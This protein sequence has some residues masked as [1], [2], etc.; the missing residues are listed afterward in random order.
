MF[1]IIEWR[2]CSLRRCKSYRM[3]SV[4]IQDAIIFFYTSKE[5]L[6]KMLCCFILSGLQ[7][8][9][10][11]TRF[12]WV[13]FLV[14]DFMLIAMAL[15]TVSS[16]NSVTWLQL[17]QVGILLR[18]YRY[19]VLV[20]ARS[21]EIVGSNPTGGMDVCCE[22]CVLSGRDL[23]D[24]LISRPEESCRLQCSGVWSRNLVNEEALAHWGAVAAITN[25]L[26]V[27]LD[28][29]QLDAH[30]LYFTIRSLHSATCFTH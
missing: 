19:I 1:E 8:F 17:G 16:P 7:S 5:N 24:E 6:R 30:L 14:W 25:E 4:L 2:P 21:A 13:K 9:P 22:R 20:T 10:I 23:C 27:S 15:Q 26:S 18:N 11:R 28:N 3:Y 12:R 29:D